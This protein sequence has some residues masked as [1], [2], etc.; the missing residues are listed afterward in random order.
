MAFFDWHPNYALG[1]AELDR[2]HRG[3]LK[4]ISDFYHALEV[5]ALNSAVDDLL[6]KLEQYAREHFR[7]EE[8]YLERY[9]YPHLDVQRREHAQFIA[10]LSQLTQR[11]DERTLGGSI[12]LTR[13]LKDWW[14]EHIL[15]S[16]MEYR[17]WLLSR[18]VR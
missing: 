4:A 7:T 14:R 1:I 18:G 8:A 15:K 6:V 9:A 12:E 16:D 10:R 11:R 13:F 17:D 2:Q 3:L 5:Q